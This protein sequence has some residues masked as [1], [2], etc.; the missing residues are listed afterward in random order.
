[1]SSEDGISNCKQKFG[2]KIV[3]D[4]LII[5]A[6]TNVADIRFVVTSVL[7]KDGITYILKG[8]GSNKELFQES[9]FGHNS[10]PSSKHLSQIFT[11]LF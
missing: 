6:F 3:S 4:G 8:V 10:L 7:D 1:M 2:P 9:I 5:N 11:F